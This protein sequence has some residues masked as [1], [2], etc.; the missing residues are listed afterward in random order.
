MN[1]DDQHLFVVRTVEDADAA[2]RRQRLRRAPQVIV[3]QLLGRGLLERVDVRPLRVDA[4][5]HVF[6]DVILAGAIHTLKDQQQ[7]VS[8]LRP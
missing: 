1:A 8:I 2:A 4:G 3:I 6:D 7:R 5:H